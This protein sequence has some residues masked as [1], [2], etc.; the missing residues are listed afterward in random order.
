VAIVVV[1]TVI[2]A[3]VEQVWGYLGDFTSWHTWIPRITSTE[4][5]PGGAG[6][7]VGSVRRLTLSDGSTIREQ[8]VVKD[9]DRHVIGYNFPAGSP[10]PVRRYLGTARLEPVTSTGATFVRWSGDFDADEAVE[11]KVA[12]SFTAVYTSFIAALAAVCSGA[13]IGG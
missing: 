11:A 8:L 1:S 4:M 5:D 10:Y 3:P 2:E 9:D 7:W 13:V 6:G 12:A